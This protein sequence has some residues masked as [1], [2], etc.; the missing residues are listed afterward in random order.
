VS[1]LSLE[2]RTS[3]LLPIQTLAEQPT[4]IQQNNKSETPV[5]TEVKQESKDLAKVGEEK[6]TPQLETLTEP[7]ASNE[8]AETDIPKDLEEEASL[9]DRAMA[10]NTMESGRVM[11][12]EK[13]ATRKSKPV[14]ESLPP[15]VARY[16]P[17]TNVAEKSEEEPDYLPGT[18]PVPYPVNGFKELNSYIRK[19]RRINTPKTDYAIIEFLV[20]EDSRITNFKVVE[21]TQ[22]DLGKEAVR[23]IKNGPNWFPAI[24]EGV[25]VKK[26]VVLKVDF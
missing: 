2:S 22:D 18:N 12:T 19:Y 13:K 1:F 3:L 24:K 8:L 10:V 11:D 5:K 17:V 21:E 25:A 20:K 23:L 16:N 6:A 26:E 15:V 4:E 7:V 9:N 14:E